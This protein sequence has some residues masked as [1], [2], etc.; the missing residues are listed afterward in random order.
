MTSDVETLGLRD[1]ILWHFAAPAIIG[2]VTGACVAGL[3]AGV[4]GWMIAQLS[5]LPG[6]TPALFGPVALLLTYFA[7]KYV[8]R[9]LSPST[10]EL[11]I[12]LYHQ[13]N[14][15][16]PI[17]QMPG[18]ILA[19][20]A[21]VGLGGSQ[22]FEST[23]AM[24]G[25][26]WSD[27]IARVDAFRLSESTGRSLRAAGASAG[28]AAVF[29]SPAAGALYGI[30]VPFKTEVDARRLAP[31]TIAAV[32]SFAMRMWLIGEQRI[33]NVLGM[34]TLDARF[35]LACVLVAAL[36]GLGAWLFAVI[37]ER[38]RDVG[39][40][41]SRIVRAL[42]GGGVLA[43]LAVAGHWVCGTWI[44]FGSGYIATGWLQAEQRPLWALAAALLVRAAGNLMTVYGGGG[45]GVFTSLACNG[46]FV[47]EAVAIALGCDTTHSLALFG[48]AC[49]LGAG[50]RLPLACMLFIAEAGLGATL[51][52]AGLAAVALAILFMGDR[53][54]SDAQV[55]T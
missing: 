34:P 42:I 38:L 19:T 31:C 13:K 15:R 2:L 4:E 16:V 18:R 23:S 10:S 25:A 30:E 28:I 3:V 17:E 54:V 48:A 40:K 46:A 49:F 11:Y 45:G 41:Q 50:Y 47:G 21:T 6:I 9:V 7:A 55:D 44:T 39:Q 35:L 26:T 53:S 52:G 33:V 37:E 36:C 5:N 22:G 43:A 24:V 32:C 51:T 14:A 12:L 29:S 8:T 20:T 1:R 27:L